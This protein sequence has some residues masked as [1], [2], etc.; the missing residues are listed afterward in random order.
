MKVSIKVVIGV[1]FLTILF[2]LAPDHIIASAN[3]NMVDDEYLQN[4]NADKN[5]NNPTVSNSDN[6]GQAVGMTAFDYIKTLFFLIIVLALLIYV[7]KFINK[8]SI[9]YQQNSIVQNLGGTSL[10]AQKSV[11]LL[12]IGD[13]IYVVGIGDDVQL[14]KEIT[15]PKQVEDIINQYNE[16]QTLAT[17][18][19]K[20]F[21]LTKNMFKNKDDVPKE[22]KNFSNILKKNISEITKERRNELEKWKEKEHDK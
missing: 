20:L 19:P 14:I 6:E 2:Q 9:N 18:A 7:L 4:F 12:R 15:D 21:D 13:S 5:K 1:L 11:Q 3:N 22:E 8:K 16:R 10:G 17:N